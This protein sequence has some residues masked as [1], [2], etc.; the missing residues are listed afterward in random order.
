[1][2]VAMPGGA[3]VALREWTDAQVGLEL[4]PDRR[5]VFLS[6]LPAGGAPA[7]D[8]GRRAPDP[9]LFDGPAPLGAVP[10]ESVYLVDEDRWI[11]LSPFSERPNDL[12]YTQWAGPRTLA[13]IAP[14][15]VYFE[16]IDKPGEKR[17]VLGGEG[18]LR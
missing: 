4:S 5:A 9:A 7:V 6:A 3:P 11:K 10:E 1:M 2:F 17:F 18:G 8:T 13:R 15:V 12:R 16:D 14:G